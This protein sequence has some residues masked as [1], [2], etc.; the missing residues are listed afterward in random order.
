MFFPYSGQIRTYVEAAAGSLTIGADFERSKAKTDTASPFL[1]LLLRA[2]LL[3]V[4]FLVLEGLY[5]FSRLCQYI[6]L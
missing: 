4:F 6:C 3:A 2:E 5:L 1:W